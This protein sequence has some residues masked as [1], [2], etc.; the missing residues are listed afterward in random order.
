MY[1]NKFKPEQ[2]VRALDELHHGDWK[3]VAVRPGSYPP[4]PKGTEIEV[5]KTWYNFYGK[6]VGVKG[7]NGSQYDVR[8]D[9]LEET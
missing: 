7:P 4:I 1:P 9:E 5:I 2:K 8:E 3:T 6:W